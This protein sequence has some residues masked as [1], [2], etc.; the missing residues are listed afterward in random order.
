MQIGLVHGLNLTLSDEARPLECLGFRARGEKLFV[1]INGRDY[2]LTPTNAFW[3][4]KDLS[5]A[6]HEFLQNSLDNTGN[7]KP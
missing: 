6:I 2:E 4:Q 5:E 7:L 1:N 3:L